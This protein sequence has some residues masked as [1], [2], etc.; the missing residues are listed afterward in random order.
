VV[1]DGADHGVA[2]TAWDRVLAAV[3]GP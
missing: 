3:L 1:V 2:L